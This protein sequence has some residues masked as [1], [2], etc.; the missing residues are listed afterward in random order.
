MGR[1][2]HY[3]VA[4]MRVVDN[5]AMSQ[6][7]L[8]PVAV[9]LVALIAGAGGGYAYDAS[10]D[11][12]IARD[13]TA[14]GVEIGGMRAARARTV[15]QARLAT[16]LARPLTVV[17]RTSKFTL[18][19]ARAGLRV[20]VEGM[21]QAALAESRRGTV[22]SRIARRVADGD[23]VDAAV[24]LKVAY[25]RTAV[26]QFVRRVKRSLDR[27]PRD[28][29][30]QPRA[31]ALHVVPAREGHV[32]RGRELEARI[33]ADLV[34]RNSN[35]LVLAR[36]KVTKPK[37]TTTAALVQ[38]HP[39]FLTVDRENKQL[40]LFK[41]L[42]LVKTYRITVGRVGFETP[43]GLYRIQNK[44]VNVAWRVP[45]WGGKL[46]GKL[47]PGGARNNPL[48]ARWM[49]I[50]DGAGI[51]GTDDTAALGRSASHGCIRMAI[52]EVKK[53]Y[54]QVPVGTSVFIA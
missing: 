17:Y 37:L 5:S 3:P 43:H 6:R 21:V 34:D 27:P 51:H 9:I 30:V 33:A 42:E 4:A 31:D 25:S 38:R 22:I 50:Y 13:V 53:L 14:G 1:L 46:A 12:L 23:R 49:G 47:I 8:I 26:T 28:A 10:R 18:S 40:R 54:D 52:P 16:R 15:L 36:A 48:K 35:R 7:V 24:A 2:D 44:G 20:D 32:I 45:D 11:D 41:D 19:P 29:S 39:Y